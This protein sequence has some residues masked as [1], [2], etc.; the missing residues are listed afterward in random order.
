MLVLDDTITNIALPAIAA[1]FSL[2]PAA[3]P[4]V[5]NAYILVF[6]GLLLLG[7][8][9]GDVFGR[10]RVLAI[11]LAIFI[12]ASAVA[13]LSWSG[14]ALI[15]ARAAQGLGAAMAAPNLLA[16]ISTTFDEGPA[17]NKAFAAYGAMSGLGI[18]GGV[19]LGGILA[20]TLGWRSVFL[21]NI[22]VGVALLIGTR[23]LPS[24]PPHRQ[25]LD[26]PSA[27]VGTLGLISLVLAITQASEMGWAA[28][29]V[30]I[31][32][33]VGG[34]LLVGFV[35]MQRTRQEPMLPLSVFHDISRSV[36]YVVVLFIGAGLMGTFYLLTLYFQN[37]AGMGQMMTG[38][39]FLPFS[40]GVIIASVIGGKLAE[41][42]PARLLA[43]AGL[44]ISS[45]GLFS[46][47]AIKPDTAYFPHIAIG[48]FLAAL[49]LG[50][51]FVVLTLTAVRDL[52]VGTAGVGSSLVNSAQQI[53]AA[54]GL[55]VFTAASAG[56]AATSE[57]E[58]L[59]PTSA[60]NGTAFIVA[61]ALMLVGAIIVAIGVRTPE[62]RVHS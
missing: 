17:R 24:T 22:P 1:E 44:V 49:G 11:G 14:E 40:F 30:L 42:L 8:K 56:A 53:G 16:L 55:A 15:I 20:S 25:R 33:I 31:S 47:A 51:A 5:I 61:A 18:I 2:A 32:V 59:T 7:G 26:I 4:W 12:A 6:G 48:L 41:R 29:P 36:S 27:V 57:A 13:G 43:A 35:I 45:G 58:A 37:V 19:L 50:A 9:L 38:L 28:P 60:G 52:P 62:A 21:I 39:A 46:L 54:L 3:L 23:L 10:R 34:G